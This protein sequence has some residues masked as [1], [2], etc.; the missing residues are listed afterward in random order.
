VALLIETHTAVLLSIMPDALTFPESG[1]LHAQRA[2]QRLASLS[3]GHPV[4]GLGVAQIVQANLQ[5]N[6]L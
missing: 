6:S 5:A 4:F 2:L 3:T 1:K